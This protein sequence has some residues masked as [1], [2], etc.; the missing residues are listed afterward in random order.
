MTGKRRV[1]VTIY[2]KV[3]YRF[4]DTETQC[5]AHG[6]ALCVSCARSNGLCQCSVFDDTGMHWDTCP[7]R[8][9]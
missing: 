2:E 7:G 4:K 1:K 6:K 3:T 9:R 5:M 8:I